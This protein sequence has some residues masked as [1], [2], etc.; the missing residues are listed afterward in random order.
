MVHDKRWTHLGDSVHSFLLQACGGTCVNSYNC[1]TP[2]DPCNSKQSC[3][4]QAVTVDILQMMELR[5]RE[6]P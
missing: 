5:P 2:G 1:L 3:N 6:G 4:T